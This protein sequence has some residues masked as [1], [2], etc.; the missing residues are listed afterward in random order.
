MTTL[1]YLLEIIAANYLELKQMDMKTT[2][3]HG[4]LHEDFYMSQP[5]GF[6]ETRG[7]H[8]IS[9]LKKRLYDLKPEPHMW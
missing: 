6:T 4:D 5:A 7:D 1:C 8:F 9:R 2:F 3:L